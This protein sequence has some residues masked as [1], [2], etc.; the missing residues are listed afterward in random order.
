LWDKRSE[1]KYLKKAN[2]KVSCCSLVYLYIGI[3]G[4]YSTWTRQILQPLLSTT[5]SCLSDMWELRVLRSIS[6]SQSW[7]SPILTSLSVTEIY[8]VADIWVSII[9][10]F[11]YVSTCVCMYIC[12]YI[13][14]CCAGLGYIV[15]FTNVLIIYQTY[16]WIHPLHFSTLSPLPFLHW[17]QQVSFLH[18]HTRV[19]SFCTVLTLLPLY[20][21]PSPCTGTNTCLG[22]DLFHS[23]V[24]GFVVEKIKN[25]FFLFE[26]KEA[27][28]GISSWYF[29]VYMCYKTSSFI[30]SI[31]SSFYHWLIL[32]VVSA[33]LTILYSFLYRR[34]VNHFHRLSFLLLPCSSCMWPSLSVINFS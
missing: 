30:S 4:K 27:T 28:H 9:Y 10:L 24:S 11:I 5:W 29:H 14:Y 23:S 32:M 33:G 15:T 26:T 17:F 34:Y 19:H 31:F 6:Y 1:N 20:T 18:L 21:L 16:T 22:Q 8:F 7:P 13:F 25:N 12:M 3:I 2:L